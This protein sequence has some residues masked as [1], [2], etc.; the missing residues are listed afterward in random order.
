MDTS[1]CLGC[2]TTIRDQDGNVIN[3]GVPWCDDC[4]DTTPPEQAMEAARQARTGG[5]A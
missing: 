2:G 3:D 5:L 1:T 4:I